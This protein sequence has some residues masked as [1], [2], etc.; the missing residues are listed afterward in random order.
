[1]LGPQ[2]REVVV[3]EDQEA[4]EEIGVEAGV[5]EPGGF[6]AVDEE[7]VAGGDAAQSP[8]QNFGDQ[9]VGGFAGLCGESKWLVGGSDG[10]GGCEDERG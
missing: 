2:R 4:I 7:A 9:C 5:L 10:V 6:E 8:E 3:G 1:M